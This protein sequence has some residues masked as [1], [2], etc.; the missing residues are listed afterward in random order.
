MVVNVKSIIESFSLEFDLIIALDLLLKIR[1]NLS[2]IAS[3]E[4]TSFRRF[5]K[6]FQ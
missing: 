6:G 1:S 4:S 2:I 5:V 3:N